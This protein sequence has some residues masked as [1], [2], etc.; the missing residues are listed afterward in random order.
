MFLSRC[1]SSTDLN[2]AWILQVAGTLTLATNKKVILAGGAL[3][4]NIVWVV[5]GSVALGAGAHIEGIVLGATSI[6]L[7]TGSSINGRLLSQTAVAL[8]KAVVTE[9]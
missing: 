2:A 1:R 8:Q 3:A 6:T 7:T 4:Q 9:P 5:T